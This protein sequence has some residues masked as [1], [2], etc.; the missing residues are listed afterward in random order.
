MFCLY[1]RNLEPYT[2]YI[3]P[4]YAKPKLRGAGN[5]QTVSRSSSTSLSEKSTLQIFI[6]KSSAESI[7][8]FG[9]SQN[10]NI[11]MPLIDCMDC[12]EK[13]IINTLYEA[14]LK[15]NFYI[16]SYP[17]YKQYL[18]DH[19]DYNVGLQQMYLKVFQQ[20]RVLWQA[21]DHEFMM[22]RFIDQP[23]IL[24]F[25]DIVKQ[26]RASAASFEYS[27][28][29]NPSYVVSDSSF[30]RVTPETNQFRDA[31]IKIVT[32]DRDIIDCNLSLLFNLYYYL[33][34]YD[35]LA[36]IIGKVLDAIYGP[37]VSMSSSVLSK[38]YPLI[39]KFL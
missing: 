2:K 17:G 30:S 10:N 32:Q 23:S 22:N 19:T 29:S 33:E 7:M 5:D 25:V 28:R 13:E 39:I 36:D 38:L 21:Y 24:F 20:K 12:T 37:E 27:V 9:I 14:I 6:L 4:K 11:I 3:L 31:I 18:I 8:E 16:Q 1:P 35:F 34:G 26:I 15:F